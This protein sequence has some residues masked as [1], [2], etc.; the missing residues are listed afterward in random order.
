MIKHNSNRTIIYKQHSL[1]RYSKFIVL[2]KG[3]VLFADLL[4]LLNKKLYT[5]SVLREPVT[6]PFTLHSFLRSGIF[7]IPKNNAINLVEE[8]CMNAFHFS[9]EKNRQTVDIVPAKITHVTRVNLVNNS[10]QM[11]IASLCPLT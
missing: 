1:K 4:Y 11:G 5:I 7:R 6:D 9:F 8:N 3:I 2:T 10:I